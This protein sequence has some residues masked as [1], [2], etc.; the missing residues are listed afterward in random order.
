MRAPK[1]IEGRHGGTEW[2]I[3]DLRPLPGSQPLHGGGVPAEGAP[4]LLPEEDLRD[5]HIRTVTQTT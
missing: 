3:A 2:T 5:L 4:A 1:A